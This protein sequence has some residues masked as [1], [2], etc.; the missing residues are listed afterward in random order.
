MIKVYFKMQNRELSVKTGNL[1]PRPPGT[2]LYKYFFNHVRRLRLEVPR[3]IL[4][5]FWIQVAVLILKTPHGGFIIETEAAV[6]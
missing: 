3:D 6:T 1:P 5:H 2:L 4:N